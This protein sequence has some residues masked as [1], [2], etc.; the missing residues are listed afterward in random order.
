MIAGAHTHAVWIAPNGKDL[1]ATNEG[2]IQDRTRD[3]L[4]ARR[5]A[6]AT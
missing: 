1:Y 2:P 4:Q 6:P 3:L 5:S